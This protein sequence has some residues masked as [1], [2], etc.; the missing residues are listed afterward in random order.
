M[1]LKLLIIA[2]GTCA[3]LT[4]PVAA[5]ES[6]CDPVEQR[7][8]G[9]SVAQL[10]ARCNISINALLAAN[11]AATLDELGEREAIAV[12]QD[13]ADEGW[14]GRAREAVVG[15]GRELNDAATAAGRSVSDYLKDQ[16]DLNRE[17]LS[18]GE[19]VGLPGFESGPSTGPSL[20]VMAED[21]GQIDIAA[22]GLPGDKEV[23]IGWLD[24]GTLK[25]IETLRTDERGRLEA[26]IERPAAIP[27][28]SEVMFVLETTDRRLRLASDPIVQN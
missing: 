18:F 1:R 5:A 25:P 28:G 11:D 15:A 16:P 20:N 7:R 14:L 12:P 10:A 6:G 17:V 27:S 26:K 2:A 24:D 22:S 19:K 3:A 9:E 4:V 21:A 8:A 23:T 13:Q